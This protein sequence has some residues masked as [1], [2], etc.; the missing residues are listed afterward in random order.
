MEIKIDLDDTNH[1]ISISDTGI[2][3]TGEELVQNLGTIAH[4]GSKSFINYLNETDKKDLSLIGQFG[5]G[6]YSA[7][8][9]ADKVTVTTR[10]Y[11]PEAAGQIWISDGTGS[12]S[13]GEWEGLQRGTTIILH[14][15]EE[16]REYV[17]PDFIKRIIKRYSSFV[18]F[19]ISVNGEAVNTVQ[20]IW[21]KNKN[22]VSPEEYQE[23]YKYVANAYDEPLF[24][25]HFTTDAPL[26]MNVLLFVPKDNFENIGF[27]RY[28]PGVNLYCRKVLIQQQS[29]DILPEWLR[30]VKGVV[31]SEELPLN[32]SRET[33]QDSALI[34]KLKRV[35]TKRFIKYLN[36][37]AKTDPEKYRKFWGK[38]SMFIKEGMATD[39]GHRD[40]LAKLL[41]FDSSKSEPGQEIS[42]TQ[43][44]ERMQQEQQEIYYLNV[45][46]REIGETS[47]YMEMFRKRDLEV[48]YTK[49]AV[50]DYIL[51]HLR[52]YEGKK[53]VSI[54]HA[55]IK[56][57]GDEEL[58]Q[59]REM[60]EQEKLA[61]LSQWLKDV[62]GDKVS[63]VRQSKRLYNN[64]AVVLNLDEITGSMQRM[65]QIM[66][67]DMDHFGPK[68]LEINPAH[69]IIKGLS[70]LSEKDD[71]FA[72]LAAQQLFDNAL[73]SAGLIVE[74]R[75]IVERMHHI[76]ERALVK[77]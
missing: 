25:L 70:V 22:E 23:F 66:N 11:Q 73:I 13:I 47:P 59:D 5:V 74:P 77:E 72:K 71:P 53:L 8:M 14:V 29:K 50:D 49:E 32:I 1:T 62:L 4:S 68:I 64:P 58:E 44:L 26:A 61:A 55:D 3:M 21:T 7:F 16:C 45:P 35:I 10:S 39:F 40:E 17:N 56:L 38:F 67:K 30:F 63:E 69:P 2:G 41:R 43:Y 76:L 42:L 18:P 9:V 57:P 48:I 52:E 75:V 33:M 28:E 51:S 24:T 36:E 54:D 34:A 12:Y 60:L 20:A 19:P 6:F 37:Q 46:S 65:M 31:D 27:G 15:K